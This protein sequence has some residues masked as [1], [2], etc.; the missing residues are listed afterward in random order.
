MQTR[1]FAERRKVFQNIDCPVR[2]FGW[3]LLVH[4]LGLI[5]QFVE[6]Y[7]GITGVMSWNPVQASLLFGCVSKRLPIT[8]FTN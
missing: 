6:H 3:S 2:A 8:E 7:T 5:A 1:V 4:V